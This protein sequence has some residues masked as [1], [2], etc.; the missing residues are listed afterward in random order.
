VSRAPGGVPRPEVA[1]MARFLVVRVATDHDF[2]TAEVP[3]V[4]LC[5]DT[6]EVAAALRKIRESEDD[7]S[8]FEVVGGK[9]V[10]RAAVMKMDG[11]FLYDVEVR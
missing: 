11:R 7:W 1:T 5:A 2:Q 10:R 8:L 6:R 4:A 3:A 9:A